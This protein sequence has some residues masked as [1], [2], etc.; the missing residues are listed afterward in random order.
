MSS[1]F[2]V[3]RVASVSLSVLVTLL[4]W[5]TVASS[6]ASALITPVDITTTAVNNP[7]GIQ[8]DELKKELL[9]SL[10]YYNGLPNNFDL[11]NSAGV[12]TPFTAQSGLTDEVYMAAI[13]ETPGCPAGGFSVGEVYFGTGTP[14]QIGRI[15]TNGTVEIPWVT[16]SPETGLLRGGIAQACAG[17]F[18]GKLVVTTTTGDVWLVEPSKAFKK[19]A[20]KIVGDTFEGPATV[21]PDPISDPTKYGPWAEKILVA[22][23]GCGCVE[24]ISETGAVV[25]YHGFTS[26]GI[27]AEGVHVVPEK[28]N[29][30]A[31]DYADGKV[32]GIPAKE[33]EP[34]VG[35]VIV[36]EELKGNITD[37]RW[38]QAA[39]G[40]NGAFEEQQILKPVGQIEGSTFAPIGVAPIC[41]E[42]CEHWLSDGKPIP[43]GQ[44]EKAKTSG[45]LTFVV[46]GQP[47]T[48]TV[49]DEETILNPVGGGSGT[50][51]VTSFTV[52]PCKKTKTGP[53]PTG[54]E[55]VAQNLPWKSHLLE[56]TPEPDPTEGME[57]EVKCHG[58]VLGIYSGTLTP[59]LG[60]STLTFNEASGEL[61]GGEGAGTLLI[62]GI[63]K[64][65]GPKG[66]TKIT[67][68][69][70]TKYIWNIE[71]T[72]T[73]SWGKLTFTWSRTVNEAVSNRKHEEIEAKCREQKLTE[74]EFE[75]CVAE[76]EAKARDE[77]LEKC[78]EEVATGK[79]KSFEECLKAHESR[80]ETVVL[81]CKKSDAGNIWDE[82]GQGLDE[83]V[84]FDLYEC[85]SESCPDPVVTASNL[86][87]PSILE[88]APVGSGI[89]RDRTR[90]MQLRIE[91]AAAKGEAAF[92]ETF[93]GE[94][95]PRW[96]NGSSKT[97]PSYDEFGE[98]SGALGGEP[99]NE[100]K[101]S[102]NDYTAGFEKGELLTASTEFSKGSK[103]G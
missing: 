78:E 8:Y 47:C 68:G 37:V 76:A 14:G 69:P 41:F 28:E 12:G 62:T 72:Q 66:D 9:L 27:G 67:S 74:Q 81:T 63:E 99:G 79:Y 20:T 4:L 2:S 57:L 86:P 24:S 42:G 39:N 18:S 49:T 48:T 83:T 6:S 64:V 44:S 65:V 54:T 31:A 96:H 15:K 22:S 103:T 89:I 95:T 5:A 82:K 91:C 16:L 35:D 59:L 87:W 17:P 33:L 26:S 25:Q 73:I 53:C 29:F 23:E 51:E 93:T 11:V 92:G 30:Y 55:I 61:K 75:A 45:K 94:P 10:N 36:T 71:K 56:G 84:L 85:S 80:K 102:G 3:T 98:G 40:G 19:L 1:K 101:I 58:K 77:L 34:Y 50:D 97:G 21:P 13:R 88:E 90:G 52:A 43:E 38:N 70:P 100:L 32:I 60:E 46:N 7:I